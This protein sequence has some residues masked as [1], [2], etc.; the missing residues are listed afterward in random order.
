MN[1]DNIIKNE[2]EYQIVK[3]AT[4]I[5]VGILK[6]IKEATKIGA[7]AAELDEL[8][9][10][11][12]K[13]MNVKPS[14]KGVRGVKGPYENNICISTNDEILH[15]IPRADRI[16][17]S[18]DLVKLDFGI[19]HRGFY[20]DHCITVGLGKLTD[21]EQKLLETGELCIETAINQAIKGNTVGDIS[22]ALQTVA[23]TAG[24]NYVTSYVGHGIGRSLHLAP[25]IPSYGLKGSGAKLNNGMILCIENQI[26]IG[27]STL[28]MDDDGWTLR[29][30][31]GSKGVM[32]EHMVLVKG[33]T[34][35]VLTRF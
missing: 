17:K 11:L 34:T 12:C 7:N 14:F 18:G 21:E 28:K 3:E 16:F 23:E 31:D 27:S 8:A 24:F 25:E 30:K 10:E 20:T 5:S 29:T 19:I 22:N 13:E 1:G 2:V 9:G 35:E 32:F 6:K 26:T 15:T 33:D 4:S